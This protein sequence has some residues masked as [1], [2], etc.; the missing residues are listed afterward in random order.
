[1]WF[2][3]W[4]RCWIMRLPP[5]FAPRV[6]ASRVSG[7]GPWTW[8]C[9]GRNGGQAAACH[10]ARRKSTVYAAR[11]SARA[12]AKCRQR[13]FAP[14][15]LPAPSPATGRGTGH[16]PAFMAAR[17]L[18]VL[19][20]PKR[21]AVCGPATISGHR[22]APQADLCSVGQAS[23]VNGGGPWT[24]SCSGVNGGSAVS[25]TAPISVSGVCG[26]A[27]GV[28]VT[29]PAFRKSLRSRASRRA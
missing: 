26:S 3:G 18:C 15:V 23:N 2:R 11:R 20:Q 8:A 13:I 10:A 5:A 17:R 16:A 6:A 29:E 1:M 4:N 12:P 9:S 24:W 21:N 19:R 25:C 22:E 27:N 28:A 7:D 14:P